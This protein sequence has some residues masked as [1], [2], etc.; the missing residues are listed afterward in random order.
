[1]KRF[2]LI[3]LPL[4]AILAGPASAAVFIASETLN[5]NN[6][7]GDPPAAGLSRVL[8]VST[9]VQSL[10]DL[11]VVLDL[12]SAPGDIAWSGDLFVQLTSP[13]GTS[14]VLINRPGL[15][16]T[17][18]VSGYG[19]AGFSVSISEAAPHDIHQYQTFGY[20]L[21]ASQQLTGFWQPDGR[22]DAT[23]S[24]RS[25]GI[26]P[27]FGENPNGQ[28]TLFVSDL[29]SGN[30]ARLNSWSITGSDV[31][32]VPEPEETALAAGLVLGAAAIWLRQRERKATVS[33]C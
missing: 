26:N 3:A 31:A 23:S 33:R 4:A 19:D 30:T 1:M 11:T 21:N 12:G 24:T 5:S 18:P 17:D 32:A 16:P 14:I 6:E 27:V 10:A 29:G 20:T 22:I 8:T 2:H 15:S 25:N 7:V 9:P 28:W 13:Q